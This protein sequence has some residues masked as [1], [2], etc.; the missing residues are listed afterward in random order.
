MAMLVINSSVSG[1][2]SGKEWTENFANRSRVIKSLPG[3]AVAVHSWTF[4]VVT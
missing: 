2:D 4:S 1:N 3:I